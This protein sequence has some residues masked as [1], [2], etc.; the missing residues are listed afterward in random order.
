MVRDSESEATF[1]AHLHTHTHTCRTGKNREASKLVD[2]RGVDAEKRLVLTARSL[3]LLPTPAVGNEAAAAGT[4]PE[5][6][7]LAVLARRRSRQAAAQTSE[8]STGVG[9]GLSECECSSCRLCRGCISFPFFL[10]FFLNP[11]L[12]SVSSE[13][14][15]SSCHRSQFIFMDSV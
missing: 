10:S 5:R 8:R 12:L 11:L 15:F 9:G 13:F 3:V 7:A 2:F 14:S 6:R 4:L 1:G